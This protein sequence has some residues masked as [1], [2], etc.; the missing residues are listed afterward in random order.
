MRDGSGAKKISIC[1]LMAAL[2][3]A[4][5]ALGSLVDVLDASLAMIAGVL[6][7][8]VD[9][10]FSSA[11]A[12]SVFATAA[13]LAFLLPMKSPAV[14]FAGFFGW[15]PTARKCLDRFPKALQWLVKL[16]LFNVLMALYLY[17]SVRLF[18]VE[19]GPVWLWGVTVALGETLFVLY[20]LA[21]NRFLFLYFLR[22]R[23]RLGF[24]KNKK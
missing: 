18:G 24:G 11:Y 12:G 16:L 1:A 10:E 4:V 7:W 3:V 15:Y 21:L 19:S 5:L 17:L 2:C 20:D 14:L 6:V 9:V 22:F 8:I 23:D 13:V